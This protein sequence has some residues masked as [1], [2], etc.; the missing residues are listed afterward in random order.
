MGILEKNGDSF[1]DHVIESFAKTDFQ[2]HYDTAKDATTYC[3][4]SDRVDKD[5]LSEAWGAI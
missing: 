2:E 3:Y 1:T 5:K 4:C